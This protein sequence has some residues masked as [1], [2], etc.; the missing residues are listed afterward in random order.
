[1]GALREKAQVEEDNVGTKPYNSYNSATNKII[2]SPWGNP[3][4]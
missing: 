1:M 2:Y 3:P 4:P